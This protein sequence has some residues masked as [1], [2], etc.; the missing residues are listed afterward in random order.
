M[1][2]KYAPNS[3]DLTF[4]MQHKP[5]KVITPTVGYPI[6]ISL[7]INCPEYRELSAPLQSRLTIRVDGPYDHLANATRICYGYNQPNYSS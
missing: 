1:C 4:G 6:L 7:Q 3:S 2:Y 5:A